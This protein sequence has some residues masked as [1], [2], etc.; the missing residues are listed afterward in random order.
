MIRARG[1]GVT[2]STI[3]AGGLAAPGV[4]FSDGSNLKVDA[5]NF[6]Y[7]DATNVLTVPAIVA[8][9]L[10][11]F[12]LGMYS[13]DGFG[14]TDSEAYGLLAETG[15]NF[16]CLAFGPRASTSFATTTFCNSMYCETVT[17]VVREIR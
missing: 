11:R 6:Y 5:S 13:V 14:G 8:N 1:G 9:G 17:Q 4:V 10:G 7:D 12:N 16:Q 2:A 3:P 15:G